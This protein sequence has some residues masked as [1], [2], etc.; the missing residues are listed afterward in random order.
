MSGLTEALW[1]TS[2]QV[3]LLVLVVLAVQALLGR[4]LSPRWSYGLWGLVILRAALFPLGPVEVGTGGGLGGLALPLEGWS[5]TEVAQVERTEG[6]IDDATVPAFDGDRS[7]QPLV[8]SPGAATLAGALPRPAAPS[9][10]GPGPAGSRYSSEGAEGPPVPGPTA[11]ASVR[12]L[13]LPDQPAAG[14]AARVDEIDRA[15]AARV[16]EDPMAV[17]STSSP[18]PTRLALLWAAGAFLVLARLVRLELHLGRRR[19]RLPAHDDDRLEGVLSRAA[20]TAG[21]ARAPRLVQAPFVHGPAVTGL[22][23]PTLLVPPAFGADLDDEALELVLLHECFHLRHR[24]VHVNV[25]LA[26]VRATFWFHP[27]VHLALARLVAARECLRDW[28]ALSARRGNAP[29]SPRGYAETL[30][31]LAATPADR[32]PT[33][34]LAAPLFLPL[35]RPRPDLERRILMIARYDHRS[36]RSFALGALACLSLGWLAFTGS[37]QD[38]P[39]TPPGPSSPSA[40]GPAAGSPGPATP[41]APALRDQPSLRVLRTSPEPAWH[42]S[43]RE[44]LD[45]PLSVD[46]PDAP[47]QDHLEVLA[48]QLGVNLVITSDAASLLDSFDL[49]L[50]VEAEGA[51]LLDHL[52]GQ[53]EPDLTWTLAHRSV[54]VGYDG[55]APVT[56]D[57]RAYDVEPLLDEGYDED[58]LTSF[59]MDFAADDWSTWEHANAMVQAMDGVLMVRTDYRTH[60]R[61]EALLNRLLRLDPEVE[62]A[63]TR[64]LLPVLDGILLD[65]SFDDADLDDVMAWLSSVT[66]LP[67]GYDE[68]DLDLL[69]EIDLDLKGASAL[70]VLS[71]LAIQFDTRLFEDGSTVWLGSEPV[72]RPVLRLYPIEHLEWRGEQLLDLVHEATYLSGEADDV[73]TV[74]TRLGEVLVVQASPGLHAQVEGLIATLA[75]LVD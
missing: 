68:R 10:P 25:V 49:A 18:W 13:F 51:V 26:L 44:R 55:E 62:A 65:V 6:G 72:G 17:T 37:A 7:E 11:S 73:R 50:R 42:R 12:H 63:A 15:G 14:P 34:P 8:G 58:D 24:D 30:L 9:T 59:V 43:L 16:G 45:A 3:A 5:A 2:W 66:G 38:G 20:A 22:V 27:L 53:V 19:Q 67:V 56:M 47:A 21:L 74:V 1:R 57:L 52:L 40:T 70:D 29:A 75:E 28:Q 32:H 36:H 35:L 41:G 71:L 4:R 69:Q 39:A 46:L 31:Q 23:R 61:A 54:I 64:S 48:L 33:T 60:A